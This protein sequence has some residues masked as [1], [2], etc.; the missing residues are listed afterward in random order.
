MALHDIP[1]YRRDWNNTEFSPGKGVLIVSM[2]ILNIFMLLGNTISIV[3][4]VKSPSLWK[5]TSYWFVFNLAITDTTIALTIFPLNIVWEI[6]GPWPLGKSACRFITFADNNFSTV[7][8]YS[9]VLVSIDKYLYITDAIHYHH[10]MTKRLTVIL[11]FTVWIGVTVFT[12]VSLFTGILESYFAEEAGNCVFIMKDSHA[13]AAAVISFFIP[14][15]VLCFTSS[16]IICIA[17]RHLKR[18]HAT[19]SFSY[20]DEQSKISTF[21][22]VTFSTKMTKLSIAPQRKS[23]SVIPL[24]KNGT[25]LEASE[26]KEPQTVL[27]AN[28]TKKQNTIL[29]ASEIMEEHTVLETNGANMQNTSSTEVKTVNHEKNNN[30][31]KLSFESNRTENRGSHRKLKSSD[32]CPEFQKRTSIPKTQRSAKHFCKLFGTVNIV[33]IFFILMFAPLYVTLM[34]DVGCHCIKPWLYEDVLTVLCRSH[35]LVNPIIYIVTD[36][37][38]KAAFKKVWKKICKTSANTSAPQ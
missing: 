16:R 9:I 4:I 35:A 33:I 25:I 13:V 23:I 14:L 24:R 38:Y 27:G 1:I 5:C 15:A 6:Y 28:E 20:T 22:E 17:N 10:R 31:H 12:C 19:P 2:S 11:I 32:S 21:D 30:I 3:T 18:I 34:I 29:E 8:A 36:R 37:K 26:S 7:S